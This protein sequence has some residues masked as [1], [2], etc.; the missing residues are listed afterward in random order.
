VDWSSSSE[1][2]TRSRETGQRLRQEM[3]AVPSHRT[4]PGG[5]SLTCGGAGSLR[6][7]QLVV[8]LNLARD[9][10]SLDAVSLNLAR[11][12]RPLGDVSFNLAPL[13]M[14][15]LRTSRSDQT[16]SNSSTNWSPDG[17]G[18]C[19]PRGPGDL[20]LPAGGF[21]ERRPRSGGNGSGSIV[22]AVGAFKLLDRWLRHL[23]IVDGGPI[24][25]GG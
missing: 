18:D 2:W 10:H 13:R 12:S 23:E 3:A 11:G 5:T 17:S 20:A 24:D 22:P 1:T 15:R 9:G 19:W 8:S 4:W 25:R 21:L 16:S 6:R 14:G 7:R